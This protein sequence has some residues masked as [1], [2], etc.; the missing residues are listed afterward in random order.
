LVDKHTTEG[1]DVDG[2]N[3]VLDYDKLVTGAF[4]H[5]IGHNLTGI[6]GD[7]GGLMDKVGTTVESSQIGG[8][9]RVYTHYPSITK[10]AVQAMIMRINKPYGTDY[11]KDADYIQAVQSGLK[12]DPTK[13]GTTG[14]IYTEKKD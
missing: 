14:R 7:P 2:K 12:P 13:Y 9:T 11:A 4:Q 3:V 6:H 8:G 10:N 5:E 1:Q